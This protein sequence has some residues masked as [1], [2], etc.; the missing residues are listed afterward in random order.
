[1]APTEAQ[2]MQTGELIGDLLKRQGLEKY[3]DEDVSKIMKEYDKFWEIEDPEEN[4]YKSKYE[5]RK[6]LEDAVKEIERLLSEISD[7]TCMEAELGREMI[8]RL[9]LFLGKNLY[10]CEEVPNA[11]L[12]FNRSL[13]RYLRSSKRLEPSYFVYVQELLNQL[14][15]LWC[16]RYNHAEGMNFL[17]RAQI[18]F[19]NRPQAVRDTCDAQAE[20]NY[21]LTMFYLAQ[22]YGG[23]KKGGLS[24]RFCAET[25]SRQLQHNIGERPKEALERDPFDCKDWVRNCCSLS[26][27]FANECMFWTAEYLLL[28]AAVMCERCQEICGT[29]PENLDEL[30][31]EVTRD[32]GHLYSIRLKFA[33]TCTE[34]PALC[35]DIWRGERKP[36]IAKQD[37]EASP[38]CRLT[39]RCAADHGKDKAAEGGTGPIKW[40]DVFPEIVHLEDEEAEDNKLAEETMVAGDFAPA[41]RRAVTAASGAAA[42]AASCSSWVPK[43]GSVCQCTLVPCMQWWN[44]G[45]GVQTQASWSIV[46]HLL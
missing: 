27:F 8:A 12:Y 1:M 36:K 21:T 46:G 40:D 25:M 6:L 5:A 43:T 2:D 45:C 30:T 3:V 4:P 39:F 15:M 42:A 13:E 20:N 35:E 19:L 26:D 23:L 17:R 24:A 33:K 18:M 34:N 32:M 28:S 29:R 10:W 44:G 37:D 38:G 22:A 31:A 7:Q 41:S 11:E 9:F 16:N 14:G